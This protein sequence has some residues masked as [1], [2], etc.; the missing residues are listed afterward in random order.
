MRRIITM[1]D[2]NP[3][4]ATGMDLKEF[5]EA[6][7]DHELT[8]EQF[9]DALVDAILGG[10]VLKALLGNRHFRLYDWCF[11]HIN[12]WE[13]RAERKYIEHYT[14]DPTRIKRITIIIPGIKLIRRP[15][16]PK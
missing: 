1:S 8:E 3:I 4:A 6:A 12:K 15:R 5:V 2:D 16:K 7:E 13:I 14:S 10:V 9:V 11:R